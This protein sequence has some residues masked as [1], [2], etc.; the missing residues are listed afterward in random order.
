M[1]RVI[2]IPEEAIELLKNKSDLTV[3]ES[4]LANSIP[5]TDFVS[6]IHEIPENFYYD[7]E[8]NEFY[9]YRHRYTGKEIHILKEPETFRFL[10][11]YPVF[12]DSEVKTAIHKVVSAKHEEV[13]KWVGM[14]D[15]MEGE[16]IGFMKSLYKLLDAL[17][18]EYSEDEF[19]DLFS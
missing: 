16:C 10:G 19:D 13:R 3:E 7:T 18:I 12:R 1:R 15:I 6:D 14:W 5:L 9:V 11:R 4:I 2:E 17:E 8:T